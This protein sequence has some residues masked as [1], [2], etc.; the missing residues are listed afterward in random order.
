MASEVLV[1]KQKLKKPPLQL[2]YLGDRVLRQSTKRVAQVNSEVRQLIHDML[3]TMYSK[4]GIGLA[5]PQVAVQKQV[6]V[7]DCTPDEPA[8]P[9]LILVNPAIKQHSRDLGVAQEG[10][11][12]IPGVY[13]DVRRPEAIQVTYKDE[14]GRPQALSASGLL[15]RVIQ[16]E[17]D[18]L[19]G[20]LFIDRVENAIALNQELS[21]HGFSHQAV[22]PAALSSK[23]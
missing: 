12:S 23:L 17:V 3:Q 14:Q 18:H 9:P 16:H 2:R 6:I 11:L 5:A 15:A 1:S 20:V 19:N 4:D 21:K 22:R 8:N 7:V 10:C 13:L